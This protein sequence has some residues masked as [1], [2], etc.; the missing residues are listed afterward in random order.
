M[1]LTATT[2]SFGYSKY[3]VAFLYMREDGFIN[4]DMPQIFLP[5]RDF[6]HARAIAD[7]FNNPACGDVGPTNDPNL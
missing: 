5:A 6:D 4:N 3:T 1:K 7:A 2:L